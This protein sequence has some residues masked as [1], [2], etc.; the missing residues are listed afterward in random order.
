MAGKTPLWGKG[1]D[2]GVGDAR[3]RCGGVQHPQ[4]E[5]AVV[6]LPRPEGGDPSLLQLRFALPVDESEVWKAPHFQRKIHFSAAATQ[7]GRAQGLLV[8]EGVGGNSGCSSLGWAQH[9]GVQAKGCSGHHCR[10]QWPR[11]GQ[12]EAVL[13]VSPWGRCPSLLQGRCQ[14]AAVPGIASSIPKVGTWIGQERCPARR[15]PILMA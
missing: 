5:G 2:E 7:L 11:R 13:A 3:A 6:H 9:S 10:G 4:K 14:E 8:P 12:W 1:R 15:C